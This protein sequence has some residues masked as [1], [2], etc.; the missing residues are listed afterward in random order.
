MQIM[1][2]QYNL[3]TT[4]VQFII[5]IKN[6]R[7]ETKT[8]LSTTL[9][10]LQDWTQ[11]CKWSVK[12]DNIIWTHYK[13]ITFVLSRCFQGIKYSKKSIYHFLKLHDTDVIRE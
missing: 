2:K 3:L 6:I 9:L 13:L 8:Q 4:L 7:V 1:R 11:N 10:R 12:S 5:I